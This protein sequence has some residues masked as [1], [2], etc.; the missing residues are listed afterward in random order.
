MGSVVPRDP[1]REMEPQGASTKEACGQEGKGEAGQAG[2]GL[3]G[4]GGQ[5][6]CCP[7]RALGDHP[8]PSLAETWGSSL[9]RVPDRGGL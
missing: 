7:Q 1:C 3:A 4:A 5:G 2:A 9:R 6:P 8:V